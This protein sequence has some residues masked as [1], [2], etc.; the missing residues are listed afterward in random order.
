MLG[1]YLIVSNVVMRTFQLQVTYH[2]L[3]SVGEGDCLS[4]VSDV[5]GSCL[6][7]LTFLDSCLTNS[8]R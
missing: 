4:C 5:H 1:K 7:S 3:T 8:H 2:A 6:D